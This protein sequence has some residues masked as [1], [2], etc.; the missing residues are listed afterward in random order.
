M[1][2]KLNILW[3]NDN[4]EA[5]HSMVFMY[6]INAKTQGWWKE[7]DI[8]IWGPTAKLVAE[9][10]AIQ[11]KIKIAQH[12]GVHIRACISCASL[13]GVVDQLKALDLEVIGMG[14]PLTDILKSDGKLL[15][16]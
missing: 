6:A 8:I 14:V 3:V 4:P 5:A 11:E 2:D 15:T 9:N 1:E 12:A 16:I 10:T 7:V 13:F